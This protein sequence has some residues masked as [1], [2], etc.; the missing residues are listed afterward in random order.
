ML[1]MANSCKRRRVCFSFLIA[2]KRA[3]LTTPI[4]AD[5]FM[6]PFRSAS[7]HALRVGQKLERELGEQVLGCLKPGG[8]R[9]HAEPRWCPLGR[10]YW[11]PHGAPWRD[12][13]ASSRGRH[14][15]IAALHKTTITRE[16]PHPRMRVA[17]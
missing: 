7:E 8:H 17:L 3:S 2:Y 6:A 10:A 9:D 13:P 16:N 14:E 11:A 12:T 5:A 4:R 1:A 15:I